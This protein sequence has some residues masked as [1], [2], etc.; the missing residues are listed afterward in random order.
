MHIQ[1]SKRFIYNS[2]FSVISQKTEISE[3]WGIIITKNIDVLE[4]EFI[5]R[6][7]KMSKQWG[8]GEPAG[9]IWAAMLFANEALSQKDIATKTGYSLSLVSPSL[10]LLEQTNTIRPVKNGRGNKYELTGSFTETFSGMIYRFME[11]DVK[12]LIDK[13]E[14]A[15]VDE[16][17]KQKVQHLV[18]EYKDFEGCLS[19]FIKILNM[20]K[21]ALSKIKKLSISR[22]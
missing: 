18:K 7:G 22:G 19:T 14:H 8:L 21:V 6:V 2:L 12:P 5:D 16:K 1:N 9:R 3:K 4:K 11:H 20:R 13:L 17:S 10:K 15:D